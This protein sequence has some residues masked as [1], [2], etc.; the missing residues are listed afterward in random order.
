MNYYTL[1]ARGKAWTN[2]EAPNPLKHKNVLTSLA[3]LLEENDV[4]RAAVQIARNI[5][6][7][8]DPTEQS[9]KY[10][11]RAGY[12]K[13]T[14]LPQPSEKTETPKLR[15][16]PIE[17]LVAAELRT[18]ESQKKY[19][20]SPKGKLVHSRYEESDKGRTKNI[21]YRHSVKGKLVHK[22][23]RLRR[24]LRELTNFLAAHPEKESEIR[25]L[26]TEAETKLATLKEAY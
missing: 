10:L 4:P 3:E 2:D 24:R 1:T 8:E 23:Y 20:K 12:V 14:K 9:L 26:I 16:R 5:S 19:T 25:P 22:V 13:H 11:A 17:E 18:T 21:K 15:V 6:L 7:E